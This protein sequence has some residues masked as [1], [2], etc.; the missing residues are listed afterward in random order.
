MDTDHIGAQLAGDSLSVWDFKK[1]VMK[2][3]KK[4]VEFFNEL[5]AQSVEQLLGT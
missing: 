2:R 4:G 5:P 1:P 3:R